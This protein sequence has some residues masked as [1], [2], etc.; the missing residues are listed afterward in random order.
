MKNLRFREVQCL[1]IVIL[2]LSWV[3]G[4]PSCLSEPIILACFAAMPLREQETPDK[5]TFQLLLET[6]TPPA[7]KLLTPLELVLSLPNP[8]TSPRSLTTHPSLKRSNS[9]LFDDSTHETMWNSNSFPYDC[10]C[11]RLCPFISTD[12][13][14][15]V[16]SLYWKHCSRL[17]A[18]V[19]QICKLI[20]SINMYNV[21]G[22][23]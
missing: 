23:F 3:Y 4:F 15:N 22:L 13:T 19:I 11:A 14:L 1:A 16:L 5:F 18:P 7:L 9:P 21:P 12:K 6:S 20:N 17:P 10:T 2:Q 8:G